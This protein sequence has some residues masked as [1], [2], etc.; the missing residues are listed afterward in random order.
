M[1]ESK[2]LSAKATHVVDNTFSLFEV[3]PDALAKV[4]EVFTDEELKSIIENSM[5]DDEDE[6]TEPSKE[7]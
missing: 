7:V 3:A 2:H 5:D 6:K 4:K 1:S